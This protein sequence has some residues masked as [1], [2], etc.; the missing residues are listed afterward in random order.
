MLHYLVPDPLDRWSLNDGMVDA[1]CGLAGLRGVLLFDQDQVIIGASWSLAFELKY[2]ERLLG[3]T[4]ADLW[5]SDTM[6]LEEHTQR[7]NSVAPGDVVRPMASDTEIPL[8]C[9]DGTIKNYKL[10]VG[11]L[12][13]LPKRMGVVRLLGVR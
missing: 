1:I 9:G 3:L 12:R 11:A 8:R 10:S 4:I 5:A 7:F 13:N 6:T 2:G